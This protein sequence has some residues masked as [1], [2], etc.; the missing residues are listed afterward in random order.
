MLLVMP[1][2]PVTIQRAGG[3]QSAAVLQNTVH[4]G[5]PIG[6]PKRSVSCRQLAPFIQSCLVIEQTASCPPR[7]PVSLTQPNVN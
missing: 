2:T 5:G 6:L 1:I 7:P 3:G 4:R